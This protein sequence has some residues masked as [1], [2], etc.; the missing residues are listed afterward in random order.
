MTLRVRLGLAAGVA[1]AVAV[2]AVVVSAYE[3]TRSN[4]QGQ[5]DNS[6][7]RVAQPVLARASGP[8][9]VLNP[10]PRGPGGAQPPLGSGQ[11][12]SAS[13]QL[14]PAAGSLG[15]GSE[16]P[17]RSGRPRQHR[18][19]HARDRVIELALQVRARPLIGR[20]HHRDHR[21]RHGD[22]GGQPQPDPQRH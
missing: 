9:G 3:G 8:P 13:G 17:W 18:L 21:H 2:I 6:I 11:G 14:A 4:L 15:T 22:S 16:H 12:S 10:G 20:D 19:G 1:V 5:L 7:M